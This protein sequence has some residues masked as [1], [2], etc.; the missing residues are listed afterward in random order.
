M[1][2]ALYPGRCKAPESQEQPDSLEMLD[3]NRTEQ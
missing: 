1:Y 3:L 2:V